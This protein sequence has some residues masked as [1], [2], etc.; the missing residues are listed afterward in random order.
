MKIISK[1]IGNLKNSDFSSKE[2]DFFDIEWYETTRKVLRKETRNGEEIALRI[3]KEKF[4]IKHLDILFEDDTSMIV[5]SVLPA[6]AVIVQPDSMREMGTICYEIG[7]Q[8][9]PIFIEKNEIIIPFEDPIYNLLNSAGYRPLKGKRIFENMLKAVPDH[10]KTTDT[11]IDMD[12]LFS[13]VLA[14]KN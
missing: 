7:N 14:D 8:H 11:C 12:R 4:R 10:S 13:K 9:I 3:L 1:I 2:I 6:E 5:A